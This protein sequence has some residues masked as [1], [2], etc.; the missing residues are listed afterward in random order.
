MSK[1]GW[2]VASAHPA[3]G[4]GL[5]EYP[6][7]SRRLTTAAEPE[8][9]AFA[10]AGENAHNNFVQVL[11]E[12]G[13]PALGVFLWLT[14]PIAGQ[15][16]P[17]DPAEPLDARVAMAAGITAFLVTA[18]SS[19]PILVEHVAISFFLCLG[20][21]AGLAPPAD[22]SVWSTRLAAVAAGFYAVSLL[23]RLP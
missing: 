21:T 3:F 2:R 20:I 15:L 4:V 7:A 13:L 22:R 23:W 9:A 1:V 17:R 12:L 6:R 14:V 18:L 5:G 11:G 16:R 8:L 10:P 19:Q